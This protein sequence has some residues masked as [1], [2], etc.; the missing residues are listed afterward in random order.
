MQ[1]RAK[2][3]EKLLGPLLTKILTKNR[4]ERFPILVFER[5]RMVIKV[6][7]LSIF[8]KSIFN[9]LLKIKLVVVG[10][11]LL[12]IFSKNQSFSKTKRISASKNLQN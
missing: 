1:Q 9:Q 11:T 5:P 8:L 6:A 3:L 7:I 12:G 4:S 2:I 10:T